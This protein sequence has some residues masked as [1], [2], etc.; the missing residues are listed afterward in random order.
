MV[1]AFV[2]IRKSEQVLR[3]SM[4]SMMSLKCLQPVAISPSGEH[5]VIDAR[6]MPC[7]IHVNLVRDYAT[8]LKSMVRKSVS[9]ACIVATD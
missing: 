8:G 5:T 2:G 7:K 4:K 9:V 3:T 1:I 6:Q